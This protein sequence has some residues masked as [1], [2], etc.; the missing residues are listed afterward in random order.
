MNNV[1]DILKLTPKTNCK[2]C[3]YPTCM[4][5]AV[6]AV[7][8]EISLSHCPFIEDAKS[9][10]THK[11]IPSEQGLLRE[12]QGKIKTTD[13][14]EK[15]KD[16]GVDFHEANGNFTIKIPYINR[17]IVITNNDIKDMDNRE[18]D[19]RDAIL[20]YNYIFFGG[21]GDLSGEWI[22]MESMPNSISKVKTL[23]RYTEE[24]L[25]IFFSGKPDE[26]RSRVSSINGV[27]IEPCEAH[28]CFIIKVLPKIP[29][30]I[31]FWDMDEED[32]FPASVKALY[33]RRAMN[34]LDIESL[35]FASERMAEALVEGGDEYPDLIRFI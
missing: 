15:I 13:L 18:I 32:G 24:K 29:I 27:I 3:G 21:K 30:K 6:G 20:L 26:L 28:L 35:V 23:K 22:G 16:L 4:A 34:F 12:L 11:N 1:F 8:D 19:P 31:H 10:E 25:A 5:F 14:N 17:T 7:N 2:K 9:I 33:D